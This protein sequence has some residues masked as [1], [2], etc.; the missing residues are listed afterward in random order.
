MS[1]HSVHL[2]AVDGNLLRAIKNDTTMKAFD[3]CTKEWVSIILETRFERLIQFKNGE[4]DARFIEEVITKDEMFK[5][6]LKEV[7]R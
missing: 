2:S 1:C 7:L 6:Y 3:F 5:A 4:L